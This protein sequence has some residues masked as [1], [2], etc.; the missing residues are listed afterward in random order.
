MSTLFI[1]KNIPNIG[2]MFKAIKPVQVIVPEERP[3]YL[4]GTENVMLPITH[5]IPANSIVLIL[6]FLDYADLFLGSPGKQMVKLLAIWPNGIQM[7]C[8][9]RVPS[10]QASNWKPGTYFSLS[11]YLT[12]DLVD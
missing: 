10:H 5:E 9:W 8:Y 2:D 7:V 4:P 6:D 12:F 11:W 3:S 1:K